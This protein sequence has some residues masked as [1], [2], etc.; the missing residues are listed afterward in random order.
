[1]RPSS[2]FY[3]IK[4]GFKNIWRNRMF[5]MASIATMSAC[6]LLFSIFFSILINVNYMIR[7]LEEE[8]GVSVLFDAGTSDER[9]K[10]IGAEI[11]K[12]E[13]VTDISYTSPEEAWEQFSQEY[14]E[15]NEEFAESFRADNPL[16]DSASYTVHVDEIEN[17]DAVVAKI[18]AIENVRQVNQSAN[19]VNTLT[20]FNTLMTYGSIAIIAILLVVAVF[21]ISNTV[22]IGISVRRH[23]IAIMKYIG[24]TDAFVRAPFIVEGILLGAIGAVIPLAIMY[25]A[26]DKLVGALL[27]KFDILSTIASSLPDSLVVF[28]TL[29]PVGLLL[30]VG[31]GLFGSIITVRKHLSV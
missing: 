31:I 11:E 14:F 16:A 26:Y 28:R 4:Q 13:H 20:A 3:N 22:S 24:A 25:F 21:L 27:A 2:L 19:A 8:V 1:M 9:V 29:V 18:E 15:G 5:S 6:I 30:G 10:E 7:T 12:L 17:Q 23:E